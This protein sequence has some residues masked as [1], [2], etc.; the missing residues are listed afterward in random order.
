LLSETGLISQFTD[1]LPAYAFFPNQGS[2]AEQT[3]AITLSSNTQSA[4]TVV[5]E[6]SWGDTDDEDVEFAVEHHSEESEDDDVDDDN[7]M[8]MDGTD[9]EEQRLREAR[10][11]IETLWAEAGKPGKPFT[12]PDYTKELAEPSWGDDDDEDD[13]ESVE[14]GD[15]LN[16]ADGPGVLDGPDEDVDDYEDEDDGEDDD[17]D[18]KMDLDEEI[19]DLRKG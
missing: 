1:V 11:D 17:T 14:G 13:D 18:V 7:E 5:V 2:L 12:K 4:T 19:S 6:T 8:N 3:K 15:D 16:E 10:D 9:L